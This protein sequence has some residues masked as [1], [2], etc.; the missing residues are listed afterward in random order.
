MLHFSQEKIK[1]F[2]AFFTVSG[3]DQGKATFPDTVKNCMNVR[4]EGATKTQIEKVLRYISK[5][6]TK[7]KML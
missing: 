4:P 5:T 3:K 2:V 1:Q 7:N 6:S